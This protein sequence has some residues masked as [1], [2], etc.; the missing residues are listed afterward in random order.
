VTDSRV[1]LAVDQNR[2]GAGS[3]EIEIPERCRLVKL[4]NSVTYDRMDKAMDQLERVLQVSPPESEPQNNREGV[5]VTPLVE[6]LMGKRQP[7]APGPVQDLQFLDPSLNPSQQDA[8]RFALEAQEVALIH[9]PPGTGKTHT[10]VEIIRQLVAKDKRVLV[11]GASNL[12]VD[13]LLERLVPHGIPLTR[14]GHPARI[15]PGLLPATLDTQAAASDESQ[16]AKD[17]KKELEDTVN[18]LAGKGKGKK[19]RGAERRKMWEEVRELR[20]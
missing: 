4:A 11:C 1:I 12:A 14:L 17:V 2:D 16:L 3:D 20:K 15:L 6:V 18:L 7:S 9:G 13:N 19:P 8:V 5:S 10:L